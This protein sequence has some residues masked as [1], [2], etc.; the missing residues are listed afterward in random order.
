MSIPLHRPLV[1]LQTQAP[2]RVIQVF[3]GRAL[4]RVCAVETWLST[5]PRDSAIGKLQT[6]DGHHYAMRPNER[7]VIFWRRVSQTA[8]TTRLRVEPVAW[9]NCLT[10]GYL[11]YVE[12]RTISLPALFPRFAFRSLLLCRP[13]FQLSPP[14]KSPG[15][16]SSMCP[17]A[18]YS[19][20][21]PVSKHAL[22]PDPHHF[23][24]AGPFA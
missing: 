6:A 3:A 8:T 15:W 11:E 24:L 7:R 2:I 5:C 14:S 21:P 1:V 13:P 4:Y 20:L 23:F 18:L 17:P 22:A 9:H 12:R 19:Y 16:P 10:L